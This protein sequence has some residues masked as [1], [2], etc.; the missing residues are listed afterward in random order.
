MSTV[1]A[2]SAPLILIGFMASGKSSVAR[3]LARLL[4]RETVDTDA[5]VERRSGRSIREIFQVSGEEAFR[6]IESATLCEALQAKEPL[7]VSTGGGIVKSAT[8]RE[9]LQ[10][11]GRDG[12]PGVDLGPT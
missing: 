1:N 6:C 7:V 11:A 2:V 3:E 9:L 12:A 8:N 5:D 10:Q 4:M